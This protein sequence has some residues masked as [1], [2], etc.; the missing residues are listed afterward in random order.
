MDV[1]R[2]DRRRR[3][4]LVLLVITS[5]ALISLDE[6]GTGIIDSARTAAQDVVAPVQDL[7]D[8]AINPVTRL[9][10]Q[11]RPGRRARGRERRAAPP[12]R[13][14]P[15]PRSRP[16]RRRRRELA[17]L[18]SHRRPPR[19]RR[20]HRDHRVGR[21]RARATSRSTLQLDKGSSSGIAVDMPVVVG[22]AA[23]PRSSARS[24]TCRRTHAIVQRID[25]RQLR[26]RRAAHP[27]RQGRAAG[28][29]RGPTRAATAALLGRR[30]Q[31]H[32]DRVQRRASR[33]DHARGR[34]RQELPAWLVIGTILHTVDAGGA[35]AQRRDAATRGRPR[36]AHHRQGAQL[37]TGAD[38]MIR[39]IRLA[40]VMII[41]RRA[42]DHAV[43]APPHRR[44]RARHR[45][46]RACSRWP[47]RTAPTPAPSSGSSWGWPSTCSSPRRSA[48]PRSRSRSPATR[49]A[50]SRPAWCG[51][52][53]GSP[54]SS[55]ASAASSAVWCSSPPGR[56]SGS[57]GC[58]RSTACA[59]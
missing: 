3:F 16:T 1:Y 56:S 29:R 51:R 4:T 55:A 48:S 25:D 12:A 21:R 52:R 26:C 17:D 59:S 15:R 27:T 30:Q 20:R 39:R 50:C 38:P 47:T 54:R 18:R 33:G 14:G 35:S 37:P 10:R 5:L 19:H 34:R 45:A 31:H 49:W 22:A 7:A 28:H 40:L 9:L 41:V 57:R 13:R 58:S 46:R 2:Q 44:R 6:R 8:D 32:H 43:H 11:P 53:R 36:R 23:R 24:P 42:A